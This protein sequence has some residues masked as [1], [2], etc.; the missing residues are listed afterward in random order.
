MGKRQLEHAQPLERS[1]RQSIRGEMPLGRTQSVELAGIRSPKG[2]LRAQRKGRSVLT[3][4]S[5]RARSA[6]AS[7]PL[8]PYISS[9]RASHWED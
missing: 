3:A 2:A 4:G 8:S 6:T 7:S 9:L 5:G 1:G